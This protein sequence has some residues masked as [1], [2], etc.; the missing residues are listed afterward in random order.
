MARKRTKVTRV[1]HIGDSEAKPATEL[2][3]TLKAVN[4]RYGDNTVRRGSS[5]IQP[6]RIPT[7]VF[8]VDFALLGGIPSNRISM[9]VGERHSGKSALAT[10]IAG[11]AQRMWPDQSVV[12]IDVEG[13]FDSTWARKLGVNTDELVYVAPETGEMAVDISEATLSSKETSLIIVDSLAAITPM[14]EI[15]DSAEDSQVAL[16]ARLIGKMVRKLNA[17][18]IK[19]R[20]RGHLVTVLFVNQFRMKIGV[21]FGDPR[22]IPGGKALEYSTSLQ[23][24]IKNKENKGSDERGVES[25]TENEHSFYINKNKLCGGPRS[26]EFRLVRQYIPELELAEGE[27]N[28]AKTI[29]AYAKKFGYYS[30]GGAS[31]TLDFGDYSRQYR[32]AEEAIVDLSVDRDLQWALRTQLIVD[33]ATAMDMPDA[34][35]NTI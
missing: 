9:F 2:G 10:M 15:E 25:M 23:M 16:Q 30:G 13:T 24:T 11:S 34:F 4:K 5:I 28:Q 7:G 27:V 20:K 32:K 19:E 3:E 1:D 31:W 33:Q 12:M 21:S 29:L 8:M 22:T 17:A 14:K 18:L 35:I 6:L 26:G